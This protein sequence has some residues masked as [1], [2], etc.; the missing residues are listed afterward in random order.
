MSTFSF[1]VAGGGY[2]HDR[3]G[4]GLVEDLDG[5]LLDD[6]GGGGLGD[7]L[8]LGV[9]NDLGS[10]GGLE[11][12]QGRL[13]LEHLGVQGMSNEASEVVTGVEVGLSIQVGVCSHVPQN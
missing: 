11:R 2:G 5:L 1:F 9:N 7:V 4:R 3:D 12:V 10:L 8:E 6:S 13:V